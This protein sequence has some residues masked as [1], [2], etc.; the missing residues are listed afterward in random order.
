MISALIS[1]FGG[2]IF[3][4]LWG[5]ISAWMTAKQEHE[6]ELARM[7]LQMQLDAQEHSFSMESL[8]L[9]ADLGVKVV[10]AQT[11]AAVETTE[12]DGWL[13]AIK[14]TTK[15]IGIAFV[16]AWNAIIRPG[17]ATWSVLMITA[18]YFQWVKLDDN[19]W[20][21]CGAA[22]GIYLADRSLFKRGK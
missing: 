10:E 12:A 21:V 19:G 18:N 9:Q 7:T 14:G 16:D 22:L 1:F 20:Q 3:R 8:K 4:M 6:H 5:E 15:T 17:V 11:Q 13:E 2:S